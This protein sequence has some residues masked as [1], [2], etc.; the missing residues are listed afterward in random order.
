MW[1][2]LTYFDMNQSFDMYNSI[3]KPPPNSLPTTCS[4]VVPEQ[5]VWVSC[6]THQSCIGHLLYM[7]IYMF[8]CYSLICPTLAFSRIFPNSDIYIYVSFAFLHVGLSYHLSKCQVY[9]LIN[10]ISASLL[11][12][13]TLYNRLHWNACVSFNSAFLSVCA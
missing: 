4:W 13:T 3:L 8:Q 7:T 10:C 9:A 11:P 5:Q 1:W 12:Y 6:F 2:I